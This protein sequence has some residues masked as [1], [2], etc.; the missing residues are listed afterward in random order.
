VLPSDRRL[1]R[2]P[3]AGFPGFPTDLADQ[4]S[5]R[6]LRRAGGRTAKAYFPLLTTSLILLPLASVLPRFALCEITRPRGTWAECFRVMRPTPQRARA[7]AVLAA[8]RVLPTTF[9]TTHFVGPPPL[10]SGHESTGVSTVGRRLNRPVPASAMVMRVKP[11]SV[12]GRAAALEG[13]ASAHQRGPRTDSTPEIYRFAPLIDYS[14]NA[15]RI[16]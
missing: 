6:R 3:L 4:P 11:M 12:A 9:G 14:V 10:E 8:A 13:P 1:G 2:S 7:S 15:R 16:D 5:P